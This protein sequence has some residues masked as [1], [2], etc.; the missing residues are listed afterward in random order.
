MKVKEIIRQI[1]DPKI[2]IELKYTEKEGAGSLGI[3]T[4]N[5]L[6]YNDKLNNKTI[7]NINIQYYGGK[8]LLVLEV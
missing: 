1:N 5:E 3:F 4:K 6:H 7:K 2:F 8:R